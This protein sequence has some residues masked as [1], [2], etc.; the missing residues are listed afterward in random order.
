MPLVH[1]ERPKQ[2]NKKNKDNQT[3][4]I[5]FRFYFNRAG[6]TAVYIISSFT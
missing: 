3:M 1:T 4:Y 5:C 6:C 2:L